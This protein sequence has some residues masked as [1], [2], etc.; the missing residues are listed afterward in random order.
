MRSS[1]ANPFEV[2]EG[3]AE[4]DPWEQEVVNVRAI[5]GDG[6]PTPEKTQPK[7]HKGRQLM[8]LGIGD[9][10]VDS[11]AD[12]SCWPKGQGDAFPTRPAKRAIALRTANGGSV[13]H[14]GEKDVTFRN[15]LD[16]ELVGLKF[17]VTD[18]RKPLLAVRRLVE[19]GNVVSFG[20]D[21][22]DNYILN[23]TTGKMIPMER[24]GG[25]FVIK[26]H[27]AAE[28]EA[29]DAGFTRRAR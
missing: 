28:V 9:I 21:Y 19:K 10:V 13:G 14:Y 15:E 27:F 12:E 2:L 8:D 22:A 26:A 18:V 11:A 25:S 4:D 5:R 24:K 23:K 3:E 29:P 20:P 16:G 7:E 17:Q 1:I 6:D